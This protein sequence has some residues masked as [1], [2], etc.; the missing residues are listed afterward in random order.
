[1]DRERKHRNQQRALL[2][3]LPPAVLAAAAIILNSAAGHSLHP[4]LREYLNAGLRT[5]MPWLYVIITALLV[6][7][8]HRM[9]QLCIVSFDYLILITILGAIDP[10]AM[11]NPSICVVSSC[12]AVLVLRHGADNISGSFRDDHPALCLLLQ[13]LCAVLLPLAVCGALLTIVNQI[14]SFVHFTFNDTMGRS[15]LS[16]IFSPIY[17]ILQTLGLQQVVTNTALLRYQDDMMLNAFI[18][19]IMITDF[20][21]LPCLLIARSF[22]SSRS[23]RLFLILLAMCMILGGSIGPC[24]SLAQLMLFIILPGTY[25]MLMICSLIFFLSSYYLAVPALVSTAQLYRP[26][27]NLQSVF[28]FTALPEVKFLGLAGVL[29]PF[30][31]VSLFLFIKKERLMQQGRRRSLNKQGLNLKDSSSPDL[32]VIG[33]LRA[34]GGLSNIS[35]VE[36]RGS[37]LRIKIEDSSLLQ[38]AL[39]SAVCSRKPHFDR[40][41][42]TFLL[43]LGELSAQVGL[44]LTNLTAGFESGPESSLHADFPI[45]PMPHIKKR[46]QGNM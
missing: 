7:S 4:L 29:L 44:R 41:H 40:R 23:M 19:S 45:H 26:D 33:L 20:I 37:A 22:F 11:L 32:T 43:E 46:L 42:S 12:F 15:L 35:R 13:A 3:L 24:V 38:P 8:R 39:L 18:N 34:L 14:E 6:H 30:I 9:L 17:L 25:F 36:Q 1:M 16:M 5:G 10:A 2:L 31:L 27:V 21:A 28:A